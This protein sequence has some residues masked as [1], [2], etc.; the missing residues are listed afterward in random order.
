MSVESI[1]EKANDRG[2]RVHQCYQRAPMNK[3]D[4]PHNWYW[5][6]VFVHTTTVWDYFNG[7]GD[8]L[9]EALQDA[10]RKGKAK[11][12]SLEG[13]SGKALAQATDPM[14]Q[15]KDSLGRKGKSEKLKKRVRL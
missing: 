11:L 15:L 6:V 9:E 14:K 5:D 3:K 13:L 7:S 4:R 12:A 8:T 10:Y 2:F 1:L